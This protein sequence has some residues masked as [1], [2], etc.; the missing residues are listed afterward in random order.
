MAKTKEIS[1]TLERKISDKEYGSLGYSVTETVALESG[2][3]ANEVY[4]KLKA[5]TAKK[6]SILDK[7]L[8]DTVAAMNKTQTRKRS[9]G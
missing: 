9:D 4:V 2:D 1:F 8:Q 7:E 6:A 5:R 3:S